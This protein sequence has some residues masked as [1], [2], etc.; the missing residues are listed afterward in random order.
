MAPPKKSGAPTRK[1]QQLQ[2]A[3]PPTRGRAATPLGPSSQRRSARAYGQGRLAPDAVTAL[4]ELL[5]GCTRCCE[6]LEL[7]PDDSFV[8]RLRAAGST[9]PGETS[10]G[11]S[12]EAPAIP[13]E[14]I[15][16]PRYRVLG[17]VGQGGMGAVY[18]AEHRR[19]QRLVALKVIHPRLMRNPA[20]VQRFHQEV[21]AAARLHHANIVHA[22]DADQAGGLH[23][24]VME[25]V[26]GTSLDQ[27]VRQRGPLPV[28]E[29]CAYARQ[30]ALG[31][32]EAHERGMVHRDIKPQTSCS[33]RTAA[34]RSST[35]AW[36]AWLTR[37]TVRRRRTSRAGRSPAPAR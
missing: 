33:P 23:F 16:H 24:L 17:L 9:A 36:P 11:V 13:P 31:L 1:T 3:G 12:G 37:R 35:S 27:V 25:Y 32:Q 18:R 7:A 28:A 10:P 2:T 30:A 34:S 26:E 8:N 21:R 14:L 4:E 15:D 29:A 5:A 20:A 22:Y 6:L 19:M